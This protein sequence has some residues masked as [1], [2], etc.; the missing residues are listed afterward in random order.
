MDD[1]ISR[2]QAIDAVLNNEHSTDITLMGDAF[3]KGY[4]E[5]YKEEQNNVLQYLADL[6]SAQPDSK[7]TSFTHK[8]LDTISRQ[9]AIAKLKERRKIFC[10]NRLDFIILPD[11][12]KARVDEI[13]ACIAALINLPSAEQ[14]IIRGKNCK[15]R[16]ENW[17]RVS[18]KWLPC[19]DVQTPNN[20][21]C[22]SAKRGEQDDEQSSH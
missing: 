18:V 20:W 2:K 9:D 16:D 22:G 3:G 10:K 4:T 17:R 12:D 5:G 15:Y 21:F 6:P 11:K 13:D 7:E 8:A 19:M 14:E 1:L